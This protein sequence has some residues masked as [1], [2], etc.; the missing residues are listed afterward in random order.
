MVGEKMEAEWAK[1]MP[2]TYAAFNGNGRV[3]P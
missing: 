2:L 3:A 1:L